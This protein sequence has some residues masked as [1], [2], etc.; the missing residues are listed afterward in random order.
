[1]T[2]TYDPATGTV[3]GSAAEVEGVRSSLAGGDPTAG[4]ALPEGDPILDAVARAL[5]APMLS[6]ELT[7]SGPGGH[8]RHL[9][10]AGTNAVTVRTSDAGPEL[11]ELGAFPF[12]VL[13][14]SMTRLVNFVPGRAP[15]DGAEPVRIDAAQVTAL[16]SEDADERL[17]AWHGVRDRLA[18]LVD[19]AEADAS[20]Q[21]VRAHCSWTATDGERTE[22]LVVHLR[23]GESYFVLVQDDDALDLVP[24]PSITA[25]E[26]LIRV[27]PGAG[28]IK[29]PRG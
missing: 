3:R 23:A 4:G 20:W 1:M 22:D 9:L 21:L 7:N 15:G 5:A 18:E 28:E 19:P 12:Q 24:V 2:I 27:L 13:P 10:E 25:W 16:A 11:G 14:G 17:A 29:D 26:T 6:L 8:Q